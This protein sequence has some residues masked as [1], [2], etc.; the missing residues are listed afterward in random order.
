MGTRVLGSLAILTLAFLPGCGGGGSSGPAVSGRG[1]APSTG[2]GD[3]EHYFPTA[4]GNQWSMN[5]TATI[6]GGQSLS[7]VIEVEISAPKTVLGVSATVLSQTDSHGNGATSES[8]YATSPGGVTCLGNNEGADTTTPYLVPYPS[9]LF[10]AEIGVVST[11][12]AVG[13]PA[14]TDPYGNPLTMETWQTIENVQYEPLDTWAGAFPSTLKQQTSISGSVSD[15][16]LNVTIPFSGSETRWLA[17]GAGIVRQVNSVTVDVIT[18]G[19]DAQVRGYQVDGVRHGVGKASTVFSLLAPD[20]GYVSPPEGVQAVASD[21]TNFLVAARN[22]TGSFGQYF[23]RWVVQCVAADGSLI[24]ASVDLGPPLPVYDTY[25]E[26]EAAI[27]FDGVEYIVVYEQDQLSPGPGYRVAL[28]AVRV[29]TDGVV[30]GAPA[31]VAP[32]SEPLPVALEPVLAFDGTRCLVC[33]VRRYPSGLQRVSGVFVSPTTGAAD[34]PEFGISSADGYQSS[35]AL[36]FDGAQYLAAWNQAAW[37]GQPHGVVAARIGMSGVVLDPGGILAHGVSTNPALACDGGN[38]L[39]LWSDSRMQPGGLFSNVYANRVSPAGQLLDGDAAT[40]GFAVTTSRGRAE[41]GLA[42]AHFDDSYMVVWLS[43]SSPGVYE[44]LY[45]RRVSSAGEPL[46]A[47]EGVLLTGWGFQPHARI[48]TA[49]GSALLTW[50]DET[51]SAVIQH[52]VRAATLHPR[53]P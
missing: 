7:G 2:P 53:G 40:G 28:M 5:Y 1:F 44:G 48:A 16:A 46:G 12:H 20:D 25:N 27:V 36:A 18:T 31:T 37:A 41:V 47:G 15:A 24:G 33:F 38:F 51:A 8:Y 26:R 39:L 9:L 6:E 30:L 52:T 49:S 32:S 35:P 29:S 19:S 45:G 13:L 43:S 21:G 4:V 10:P 14:G 17:P 23:S 34:G 22:V 50:K 11:L 3:V 42:L